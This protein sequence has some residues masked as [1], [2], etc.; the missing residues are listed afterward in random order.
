MLESA[1]SDLVETDKHVPGEEEVE[2]R[3]KWAEEKRAPPP[4][5]NFAMYGARTVSN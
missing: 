4:F 2:R 3:R 5:R 1:F